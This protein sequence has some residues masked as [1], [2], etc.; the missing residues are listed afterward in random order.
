MKKFTADDFAD[1]LSTWLGDGDPVLTDA[2]TRR[3]LD[4]IND[5]YQQ[6]QDRKDQ[7]LREKIKQD[8]EEVEA[9]QRAEEEERNNLLEEQRQFFF[10][11]KL[12][13]IQKDTSL[14]DKMYAKYPKTFQML[15]ELDPETIEMAEQIIAEQCSPHSHS[16]N[17]EQIKF[18]EN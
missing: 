9:E 2:F 8:E 6:V 14:R 17:T 10:K 5:Q 4:I 16:G 11:A 18:I 13:Q 1:S 12:S 15:C 3:I 7:E